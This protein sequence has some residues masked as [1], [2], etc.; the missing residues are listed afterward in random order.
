MAGGKKED[1]PPSEPVVVEETATTTEATPLS[2][3]FDPAN[4][5]AT[6]N[7]T[8]ISLDDVDRQ[9]MRV[10]QQY[11]MQGMMLT[12]EQM[13]MVKQD[14]LNSLVDQKLM[15]LA[16]QNAGYTADPA[17]VEQEV[18]SVTSQFSTQDEMNTALT[19]QGLT[20][21]LLRKDI[22][23]YLVIQL[24][25]QDEFYAKAVV[26]AGADQ[27]FYDENPGHF[28]TPEQVQA[29]H[30]LLMMEPSADDDTRADVESRIKDIQDRLAGGEDFAS[31]AIELSE[32]PSGPNGGD[33]GLFGRGQMVP[34]F[35]QAA[36]SLSVGE[37]SDV[38][39]TPYGLHLIYLTD[40]VEGSTVPFTEASAQIN[41]FLQEQE[42]QEMVVAF[43]EVEKAAAQVEIM[44]ETPAP[45]AP[46]AE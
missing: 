8:V 44:M 18:A 46:A 31:L 23:E 4:T 11:Q 43:L 41:T 14:V 7:G 22:A 30:I 40:R 39:E 5:A 28:E 2:G 9:A 15:V 34:E 25:L 13:I 29:S 38:V 33:L 32:G 21:D 45:A 3:S 36:W 10:Q 27:A 37:V 19:A 12:P 35:E 24:F 6:V 1:T 17:M 26:E 20:L 42:A 16:A